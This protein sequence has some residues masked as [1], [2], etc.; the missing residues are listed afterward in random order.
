MQAAR[1]T[2]ITDPN[3]TARPGRRGTVLAAGTIAI[4]GWLLDLATKQWALDNL[5]PAH[6]RSLLG[7]FVKLRLLF[8]PGAAFSVGEGFTVGLSIFAITAFVFVIGFVLPRVRGRTQTLTAGLLLAGIAGNLTDRLFRAPGPF[9]GHV[10]DMISLP[11]FA[12]FNVADIC[13]TSAAV[14]MVWTALFQR[15]DDP[16]PVAGEAS[17]DSGAAGPDDRTQDSR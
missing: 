12:I 5:D 16:V 6:P 13:I 3:P 8:N 7:G 1:G 10:V 15:S 17:P 9:R 4:G 11:Y 2:P 14:L